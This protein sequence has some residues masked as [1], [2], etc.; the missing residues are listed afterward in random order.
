[1]WLGQF[2]KLPEVFK[3][4][5]PM[6]KDALEKK[7]LYTIRKDTFLPLEILTQRYE[8]LDITIMVGVLDRDRRSS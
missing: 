4:D 7:K 6:K 8:T 3:V 1:M 5:V 2:L